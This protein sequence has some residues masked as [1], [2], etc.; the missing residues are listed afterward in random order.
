M[1]YSAEDV[2][3]LGKFLI[4]APAF[5]TPNGDGYHDLWS[6]DFQENVLLYEVSIYDRFGKLLKRLNPNNLNWDGKYNGVDMP[7]NEYWFSIY[8]RYQERQLEYRGHFTLKR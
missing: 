4:D 8:Y 5:F 3:D 1:I 2:T 7:S 6:V